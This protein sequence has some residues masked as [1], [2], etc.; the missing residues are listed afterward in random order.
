VAVAWGICHIVVMTVETIVITAN[1]MVTVFL[2]VYFFTFIVLDI[3]DR[4][5]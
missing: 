1:K 2:I 3:K 4:K 5:D